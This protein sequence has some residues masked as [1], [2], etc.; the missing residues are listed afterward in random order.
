[1]S[2]HLGP[3]PLC[4]RHSVWQFRT[5]LRIGLRSLDLVPILLN[6]TTKSFQ[7]DIL[8]Q[9][10][11]PRWGKTW[12]FRPRANLAK[13]G[14]QKF[15]NRHFSLAPPTHG[16][17][18]SPPNPNSQPN[19]HVCKTYSCFDFHTPT[20]NSQNNTRNLFFQRDHF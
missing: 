8:V 16:G 2:T 19:T 14:D 7:P 10:P 11:P 1:M 12:V 18:G 17:V 4:N 15:S 5:M 20:T 3:G 6:R 13:Q 9:R